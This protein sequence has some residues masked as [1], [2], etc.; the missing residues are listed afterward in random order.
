MVMT[1]E[2][3]D[4]TDWLEWRRS[5][6]GG[7]DVS[8]IVGLSP[9][10]SSPWSVWADK[11]GL[12]PDTPTAAMTAGRWLEAAIGPWFTHETGLAVAGE[13]TWCT[14]R[15]RKTHLCTTDGFVFE[16]DICTHGG[17]CAVHPGIGRLHDLPVEAVP[18]DDALGLLE[19]KVTGPGKRW[20]EIPDHYQAQGQWQMHVTDLERVWIAVLMGRRLD[21]H[22]LRRDQADI[23]VLTERVDRFWSEHVL[24]GNPPPVDASDATARA[25]AAVY[26]GGG[27]GQGETIERSRG[28]AVAEAVDQWKAAKAAVKE[29]GAI[30]QLAANE[31]KA[32]LRD[33]T[34]LIV[35][36]ELV[37]SWRPQTT[38]RLDAKALKARMP[39]LVRRFTTETESRVLRSHQPK[40]AR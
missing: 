10:W 18:I 9:G 34:E 22:E 4:R 37:A 29:H 30:E 26:P 23:D 16:R 19:I 21:V 36:G 28:D 17:D 25:L 33:A 2:T 3:A 38:R 7:S 15:E 8:G 31:I 14:H 12:L 35:D 13:Q 1:G 40:G 24:T 11:L 39:R 6:T 32:A 27:T 5:G 20:D